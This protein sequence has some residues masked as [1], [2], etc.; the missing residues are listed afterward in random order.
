MRKLTLILLGA[1]AVSGQTVAQTCATPLPLYSP[2][3]QGPYTGDTCTAANSLATYGGTGS[4]QTEIVYSFVA[5]NANATLSLAAIGGF[6]GTTA[7]MLM[8]PVCAANADPIAF[9]VPGTP[10]TVSGLTNGQSYFVVVTADPGGP[11]LGCGQYS[12]SV[13]GIVPVALQA[14]SVE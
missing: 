12:L 3:A 7:S 6:A 11:A 8:L 13:N 4:P 5:Q 14:F 1:L 9:G 10:M 2:P